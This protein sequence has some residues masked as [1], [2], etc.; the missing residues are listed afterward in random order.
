V[1]RIS[2]AI[3]CRHVDCAGSASGVLMSA[4][5]KKFEV[6]EHKFLLLFMYLLASLIYYPYVHEGTV[7]YEVFRVGGS[8]G[9]FLAVYAVKVRR[10]LLICALL[11]AV[12]AVLHEALLFRGSAGLLSL[13]GTL[14]SFVFDIFIVVLMFRRVFT[15]REVK[16]ETIFGA[17]CIYLLI[18]YS[19]ASIYAM[20]SDL[21]PQ[22]FYFDPLTN[23]GTTHNRFDFI[24][25][26]FATMTSMGAQGITPVTRHA[27]SFTIMESTL[28]VLYLAVLI[29]RL[30]AG[31]RHESQAER[32]Q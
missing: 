5:K 25:Y 29:A 23:I 19:F 3:E 30:M 27:R 24:Y 11:L 6:G 13:L 14:F 1:G 18:G 28:G 22:G 17:I 4:A 16:S 9:I 2:V 8:V 15:E 26:S 21:Q 31:Y 32:E 20:I 10:M 7:S 12:P